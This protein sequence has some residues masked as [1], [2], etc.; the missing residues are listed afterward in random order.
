MID[1][2]NSNG[3][4]DDRVHIAE[5]VALLGPPPPKFR[6][7]MRLGFMFW[8][9]EGN[10]T[11]Q[12]P[13]PDRSFESLA[14]SGNFDGYEKGFLQWIRKAMQWDSEDRPTALG[15][16]RHEWMSQKT[17]PK[18]GDNVEASSVTTEA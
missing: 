17:R 14:V 12:A 18:E 13:I 7:K 10:W 15:L 3:A 11:G 6:D 8:D 5:L 9:K 2:R 1:G 16:L 4:F